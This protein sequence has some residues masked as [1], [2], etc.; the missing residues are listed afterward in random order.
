MTA[1]RNE[2]N[3]RSRYSEEDGCV[4][5]VSSL[6]EVEADRWDALAGDNALA[7]HGWLLAAEEGGVENLEPRYVL[8]HQDGQLVAGAACYVC[9][10]RNRIFNPD[11]QMFRRFRRIPALFDISF[12]PAMICCPYRC[13]GKHLLLHSR[14]TGKRR[15]QFRQRL[16]DAVEGLARSQSLPLWFPH[17][18]AAE[19]ESADLLSRRGY[20]RTLEMPIAYIQIEWDSFAGYLAYLQTF[21]KSMPGVVRHEM[22]RNRKAGIVIERIAYPSLHRARLHELANQHYFRHNKKNVFYTQDFLPKLKEHLGDDLILYGA[23][24]KDLLVGFSALQRRGSVAYLNSVGIDREATRRD[25]TY[26]NLVY[27][28]PISD[29]I[30]TGIRRIY[31]GTAM[32]GLK[33]RRGCRTSRLQILYKGASRLRHF[34]LRPYFAFHAQ[35]VGRKFAAFENLK[36][37]RSGGNL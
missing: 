15:A 7:S 19:V 32:Y 24:R 26:F 13:F 6:R 1:R 21:S 22:N 9:W 4:K 35:W 29:A 30:A 3:N 23:F 5:I 34:A 2:V 36:E 31:F 18:A 14:L 33:A 17:L 11:F 12:L 16:L 27:Y 37:L 10:P 8:V 20:H 25:F 28:R